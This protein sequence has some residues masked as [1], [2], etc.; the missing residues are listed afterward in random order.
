MLELCLIQFVVGCVLV[1]PLIFRINTIPEL[2]YFST[3][4]G[5]VLLVVAA[6]LIPLAGG[7]IATALFLTFGV[8]L[9]SNWFDRT[10]K[11]NWFRQYTKIGEQK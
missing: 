8:V 4:N 5:V 7:F 2:H 11:D 3:P 10:G 9:V 1:L 6:F